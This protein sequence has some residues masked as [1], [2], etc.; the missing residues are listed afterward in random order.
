M[1]LTKFNKKKIYIYIVHDRATY[2][3]ALLGNVAVLF[4]NMITNECTIFE[5][6]FSIKLQGFTFCELVWY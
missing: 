1:N 4:P 3:I 5:V 6:I 2:W